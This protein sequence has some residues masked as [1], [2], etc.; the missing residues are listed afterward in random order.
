MRTP[1]MWLMLLVPAAGTAYHYG[2]GQARLALDQASVQLRQAEE[3]IRHE[4]FSAAISAYDAALS[5]IPADRVELVRSVRLERAKA[6]L[7]NHGLSEAYDELTALKEE[8]DAAGA[9]VPPE[10]ATD[11]RGTMAQAQ[12]YMTWLMRLEGESREQWEPDVEAA[13][14]N[15]KLLADSARSAGDDQQT[16]RFEGD[17][18][19]A[20][21]LARLD[22]SELQ[23][24][25]LPKQ[26]QGC[27]SGN[28]KCKG[29]G[30]GNGRNPN[31][32]EQKPEDA[33]GAGSGPP[34]D[35]KGS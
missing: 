33:R 27:C 4:R 35:E 13:R 6:H 24:L 18:E 16:A 1:I 10:F 32:G 31:K 26:C 20:V 21:R 22:L 12:Y 7:Q 25:P 30:K 9:L 34:P 11:L 5:H 3:H 15:Y 29:K 8:V 17:L 23:G 19:A 28:C 14:Q 2:P